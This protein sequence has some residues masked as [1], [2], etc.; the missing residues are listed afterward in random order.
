VSAELEPTQRAL[1]A[2]ARLDAAA[3]RSGAAGDELPPSVMAMGRSVDSLLQRVG[4]LE[5]RIELSS[6]QDEWADVHAANAAARNREPASPALGG[7]ALSLSGRPM[8]AKAHA[9][10]EA[11]VTGLER[12]RRLA[13]AG[14]PARADNGGTGGGGGG[15]GGGAGLEALEASVEALQGFINQQQDMLLGHLAQLEASLGRRIGRLAARVDGGAAAVGADA[16]DALVPL[17]RSETAIEGAANLSRVA[18]LESRQERFEASTARRVQQVSDTLNLQGA[19][20]DELRAKVLRAHLMSPS[21]RGGGA[22]GG[23]GGGGSMPLVLPTTGSASVERGSSLSR[24]ASP[25]GARRIDDG[26][27]LAAPRRAAP[28]FAKRPRAP[29]LQ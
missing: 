12:G 13:S 25:S 17:R 5:R 4:I 21:A 8:L 19:A 22:D 3:T 14:S 7:T 2:R 27:R 15:G 23:G 9:E 10:L 24:A 29:V 1:A 6:A 18:L 11:R 20:L 16:D 28:R 26:A